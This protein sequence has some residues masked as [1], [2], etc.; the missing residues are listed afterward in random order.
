MPSIEL[1]TLRVEDINQCQRLRQQAGWNQ[2]NTDWRRFLSF[3]PT[4]CFVASVEDRI[5]GTV[6]TIAYETFGWVAMVLVDESFRRQGIGRRMLQAGIEHLES[7][8]LTVKLDAT[9]AGKLLYDTLG[10]H[11]EYNAARYETRSAIAPAVSLQSCVSLPLDDLDRLDEYDRVIFGNSRQAV[12]RSYLANFPHYCFCLKKGQEI[13]G[14]I[15]ARE[16]MNAFHIGPWVSNDPDCARALFSA[17]LQQRNPER[18]F[19]D[20]LEPNPHAQA[21]LQECGFQLQRPFIR[22]YKGVNSRPGR[23]EY[24]FGMSGPELG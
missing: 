19:V 11:D 13:E 20:I 3:N 5:V 24:V 21:I 16:G 12:L 8:G 22:M 18:I 17:C 2:S 9:P 14:Y 4:G 15:M 1:R 7:R 23:P 6:C 10:F